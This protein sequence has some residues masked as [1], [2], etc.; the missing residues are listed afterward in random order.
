MQEEQPQA[1]VFQQAQC[2]H[3][4]F[5][6]VD[7]LLWYFTSE[8]LQVWK[9]IDPPSSIAAWLHQ[10][11]LWDAFDLINCWL[12]SKSHC[13]MTVSAICIA[14]N[15]ALGLYQRNFPFGR[16]PAIINQIVQGGC[17]DSI[18]LLKVCN[19]DHVPQPLQIFNNSRQPR[20]TGMERTQT[21]VWWIH[22]C[23]NNRLSVT[24]PVLQCRIS[25]AG[26]L[27]WATFGISSTTQI[28]WNSVEG[29]YS[30]GTIAERDSP[31]PQPCTTNVLLIV[32]STK[33]I[34]LSEGSN[35]HVRVLW[36]TA[37]PQSLGLTFKIT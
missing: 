19:D 4:W 20:F 26:V 30:L 34:F 7:P 15:T 28:H 22:K 1:F 23:Y 35:C 14:A 12:V 31:T 37:V 24:I 6:D 13:S 36:S 11:F 3:V 8:H 10:G 5:N 29:S 17:T 18:P 16:L 21:V 9:L 27:P 25:A 2:Y 32:H 33:W